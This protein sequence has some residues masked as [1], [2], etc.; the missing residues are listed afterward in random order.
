MKDFTSIGNTNCQA[1]SSLSTIVYFDVSSLVMAGGGAGSRLAPAQPLHVHVALETGQQQPHR[2]AVRRPHSL[3]VLIETD[4]RV[5]HCLGEGGAAA[6][7][8]GSRR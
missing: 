4:E 3:A 1:F 7:G 2:I 5:I 8:G 6:H